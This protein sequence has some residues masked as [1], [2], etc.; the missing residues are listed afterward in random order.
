MKR[1]LMLIYIFGPAI[2][3]FLSVHIVRSI[4]A[5]SFPAEESTSGRLVV[6]PGTEVR[7]RLL[8]G[9]SPET[10]A[11]E[12]LQGVTAEACF[13]GTQLLI[14]EN[15]RALVQVQDIHTGHPEAATVTVQLTEFLFKDRDVPVRTAPITARLDR[16]SDLDLMS[17]AAG[18]LIGGAVGAA[19][20][21]A[22]HGNP[23][24]GAAA[25]GGLAAGAISE[26]GNDKVLSF[27]IQG[28]LDLTGIRW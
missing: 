1:A 28:P 25:I 7:I 24:V 15:T 26:P 14:P 11:G 21:A 17:R 6:P 22:V 12:D 8:Q 27:Q 10:Q 5:S 20:S 2:A 4:H 13:S 18:G 3:I 16:L 9:I 19:S 23:D